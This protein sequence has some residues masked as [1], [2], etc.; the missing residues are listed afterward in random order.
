[1]RR[2]AQLIF[3]LDGTIS[4]P[5]LGI[6]RS[7]EFALAAHGYPEVS[8]ASVAALI[9]PPLDDAFRALIADATDDEIRSLVAKYRERYADVGYAENTL[10]HGVR[11]ALQDLGDQG[12]S[13]GVCTSKRADFA[14]R[15]LERFGVREHFQFVSGGDVGVRKEQQL[16]GLCAAGCVRLAARMIGD[17]GVDITA[18]RAN[19]LASVGVL[20]G[21]GTERE[22]TDAGADLLLS[23]PTQLSRLADGV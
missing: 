6:S 7:V 10:Y 22:L 21:Y 16:A 17:R 20:W 18:A 9:G 23:E 15:I 5:L 8:R 1:M 11:E 13:L 4:D 3:D 19:G 14:E 2:P 12:V